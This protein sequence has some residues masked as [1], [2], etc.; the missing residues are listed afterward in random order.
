ML[1]RIHLYKYTPR[2][3][4]RYI[5]PPPSSPRPACQ[6]RVPLPAH[7]SQVHLQQSPSAYILWLS[8]TT[9]NLSTTQFTNIYIN[10]LTM[11]W[12]YRR[13]KKFRQ[14]WTC[15]NVMRHIYVYL[16]FLDIQE[17]RISMLS[18]QIQLDHHS[19]LY[20]HTFGGILLYVNK[21]NFSN[22][23]HHK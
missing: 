16:F 18:K 15:K 9:T 11:L 4:Y 21:G 13:V 19:I 10:V 14:N 22:C 1:P 3:N 6:S 5:S 2:C 12:T 17:E 20:C 8:K 7:H 23:W